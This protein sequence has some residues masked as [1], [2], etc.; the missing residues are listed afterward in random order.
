VVGE[1]KR[2]L[3]NTSWRLQVPRLLMEHSMQ[4]YGRPTSSSRPSAAP[5]TITELAQRLGVDEEDVLEAF[6]GRPSC[7]E[8]FLDRPVGDHTARCLTDLGLPP[9][10]GRNQKTSWSSLS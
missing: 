8:L 1:I 6:D 10:P 4:L 5:L 2:H 7:Q 3:R 9:G